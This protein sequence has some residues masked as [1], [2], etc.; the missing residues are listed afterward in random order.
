[1]QTGRSGMGYII[2]DT[3]DTLMIMKSTPRLTRAREWV[4]G[5]S[6]FSEDVAVSTF[7]ATSRTLSGF[8]SAHYLS[9]EMP[10]L[11]PVQK[12]DVGV[13]E[14]DLYIEKATELADSLHAAYADSPSG[15]PLSHVYIKSRKGIAS[16]D[17][18][19]ATLTAHAAGMQLE[20]RYIAILLGEKLFWEVAEKCIQNLDS[21]ADSQGLVSSLVVPKTGQ[22]ITPLGELTSLTAPYYGTT[23]RLDI[24]GRINET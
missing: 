4:R 19:G 22:F 15:V 18:G 6:P 21:R 13:D 14:E 12:E 2:A 24:Q 8:L 5:F 16:K 7:E 11:A 3:L 23:K 17:N 10:E 9:T 1:M 20:F